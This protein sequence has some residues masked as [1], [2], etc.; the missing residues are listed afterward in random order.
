MK[1][2]ALLILFFISAFLDTNGQTLNTKENKLTITTDYKLAKLKSYVSAHII[3][4][5]YLHFDKPYYAVGDTIYFKAYL[6]MGGRHQLSEISNVLYVD[7]IKPNQKIEK[8]I[9]IKIKGGIG[10]GDFSIPDSLISGAYQIR[11]YTK[12]MENK[13]EPHFFEQIIVLGSGNAL[14]YKMSEQNKEQYTRPP[15]FQFFPE[16]GSLNVGIKSKVAF[17]AV[18][19]DGKGISAKGVIYDN[20]GTVTASFESTHLGMG[21]FY[22]TPEPN[23]I[24]TAAVTFDNGSKES[25]QLPQIFDEGFALSVNNDSLSKATV[26]ISANSY[27]FQKYKGKLFSLLISSGESLTTVKFN[28]D[29]Q[30]T[31]FDIIKRRLQ[32]GISS[33]TLFSEGN[34]PLNERLFFVQKFDQLSIKLQLDKKA[35]KPKE[36]INIT[37]N[38]R[39]RADSS[40]IGHFSV[41]VTN[42]TLM[43]T[44]EFKENSILSSLLLNSELKGKIEQPGY[45]FNNNDPESVAKLD[46]VMLTNGFRR[47]DWKDI[48][49]NDSI[50][51]KYSAQK[52][53]EIKGEVKSLFGGMVRNGT[54]SLIDPLS[55]QFL[56]TSTDKKGQFI[57]SELDFTDS[58][59]LILQA[60][61]EHGNNNT[62]ISYKDENIPPPIYYNGSSEYAVEK[63]LPYFKNQQ[64][65]HEV[66]KNI[67]SK[68][69]MLK[70]VKIRDFEVKDNYRS[71]VLGGAGQADQV[72]HMDDIKTGGQL[73]DKLNGILRGVTFHNSVGPTTVDNIV[74]VDGTFMPMGFDINSLGND[75]ETVEYLKRANAFIYGQS[76]GKGVIVFTTRIGE[77]RKIKDI[78]SVGILPIVAKGFYKSRTFYSPKYQTTDNEKIQNFRST[79]E[80]IPE[81]VTNKKGDASFRFFNANGKGVYRIVVEGID[82]KGNIGKSV[83]HYDVQ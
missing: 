80:W 36:L 45:Y 52:G 23:K 32:T 51:N 8:S 42:E 71:S 69:I 67:N 61:N 64:M 33:I 47:F 15:D 58:T 7:L 65:Q 28:L 22:F 59:K 29:S 5:V 12:W 49:S 73:S 38:A 25:L 10:W 9:L 40:V 19:A 83:Y 35:Y 76:S 37:L 55:G 75:V 2:N 48:F 50:P 44:D 63:L 4:N 20:N 14:S 6:T 70:E 11:A 57:F 66:Y 34:E 68:S 56:S 16:G 81:L 53:L 27:T 46:L 43:P 41:S 17:K 18:L 78:A 1:K 54:V 74:I 82:V 60:T 3:E 72:I 79:V 39:D 13:K 21:Y 31:A 24:Y 62:Y 30:M 26:N 77:N